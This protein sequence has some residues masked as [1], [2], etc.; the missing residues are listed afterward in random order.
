M[1]VY[2][3]TRNVLDMMRRAA[4]SRDVIRE[5]YTRRAVYNLLGKLFAK[6][7]MGDAAG[8]T[9]FLLDA[10]QF[11]PKADKASYTVFARMRESRGRIADLLRSA[12]T[13]STF[14]ERRRGVAAAAIEAAVPAENLT[15]EARWAAADALA[16]APLPPDVPADHRAAAVDFLR[17]AVRAI[18]YKYVEP[19]EAVVTQGEPASDFYVV[20]L[21]FLRVSHTAGGRDVVVNLLRPKGDAK[22][23]GG[24]HEG[25]PAVSDDEF[26]FGEVALLADDPTLRAEMPAGYETRVR[27]ATVAAI[28]PS[29]V[30]RIPGAVFKALCDKFADVKRP[31]LEKAI[32]RVR[33]SA[34]RLPGSPATAPAG[35]TPRPAALPPARD[36]AYFADFVQLGLYQSQRGLVLD[37]VRCTRCDECT[38]ACADSH[39][40]GRA[41]LLREGFRFGDFLVATSCRQCHKPYCMD[42]CPVD[43]IHRKGTSGHLEVRIEDHCIG[44]GLCE[45]NCPYGSIHLPVRGKQ[46]DAPVAQAVNCDLCVDTGHDP[47]CVSAC[48]HDAAFRWGGDKLME[49]VL[50]RTAT[51]ALTVM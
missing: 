45:R 8:A 46:A 27:T 32:E 25:G 43:A 5:V 1:V 18:E 49:T 42:G 44:C 24:K 28:D 10:W 4:S 21:G 36:A 40:D 6:G 2:E 50:A 38:R 19:G 33:R 41:R 30:L 12:P 26:Y 20:N 34:G 47:F 39:P 48:P 37:L 35:A 31:F 16:K 23:A 17:H 3:V 9:R 14:S 7:K 51:G 22:A 11:G 29:E 13:S 15:R